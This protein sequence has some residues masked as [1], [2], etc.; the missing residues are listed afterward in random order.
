MEAL[1]VEVNMS[2]DEGAAKA[3][4]LNAPSV[5]LW[6]D[7][8]GTKAPQLGHREGIGELQ[9]VASPR[10]VK[11][12]PEEELQERWEAQWQEFL[13]TLQ[14][15][16]SGWGSLQKSV[17]PS[18]WEDTKA[19]LASFEQV[20][21]ACRW[22]R[23]KWVT[24]LLP[25]LSG[26]AEQAFSGLSSPDRGDYGK[27]KAA[28]LQGEAILR[29]RQR[30]HFRQFCYRDTEG[31]RAVYSR[32]RELC[33]QWLRA[34]RHTKEEILELLILEQFLTVLPQEMQSWVRERG[35]ETCAQAVV[36]AEDFLLKQ[37][38]VKQEGEFQLS[39]PLGTVPT[40]VVAVD[41]AE[42]SQA[43]PLG[44]WQRRV[45]QAAELARKGG[46][47]LRVDG[48]M[49][50]NKEGLHQ[51]S[52][53]QVPSKTESLETGNVFQY[54]EE[55]A[56]L[57]I[58]REPEEE[59]GKVVEKSV[60]ETL[61]YWEGGCQR[62]V[63]AAQKNILH[64]KGEKTHGDLGGRSRLGSDIWISHT[65]EKPQ[66][67]LCQVETSGESSTL[68]ANERS[69]LRE[70]PHKYSYCGRRFCHS[71]SVAAHER[72]Y[73]GV[74]ENKGYCLQQENPEQLEL[75]DVLLR[76]GKVSWHCGEGTRLGSQ[77]GTKPEK[78]MDGALP[79][80]GG[81]F[82][83]EEGKGQLK[84][85][86]CH[87]GRSFKYRC[88]LKAHE[89]IHTGERP[90]KCSDCGRS[91]GKGSTLRAHVRT[92]TGEKPYMCSMCGKRFTTRSGLL[93]HERIHTGEKPY[94]CSDCGRSFIQKS[95]LLAHEIS[96]KGE[97]SYT[98]S[99]CGKNFGHS[100]GLRV[101]RRIHL[102]G[103]TMEKL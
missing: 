98:C 28:I 65:A 78:T 31:P 88:N 32:L 42:A 63:T 2:V 99:D 21:S 40:M 9:A 94:K 26:E 90:H 103:R 18:P 45:C 36:L 57:R 30:Q 51:E 59:Q 79:S 41:S 54:Y 29:E 14:A 58:Q 70:K 66:E 12:E 61:S 6:A 62:K 73:T 87:C 91:F 1:S 82:G 71:E 10:Q 101:H 74:L 80:K 50:E 38:M 33:R 85:H 43:L 23:D 52:S 81:N 102:G 4:E 46:R 39:R 67:L 86:H 22:P 55:A 35:P 5:K 19:F 15:P 76:R 27:V 95:C 44:T 16:H 3:P 37:K 13:R 49:H 75:R 89:R 100:S 8:G 53:E 56:R 7:L 20:A 60:A 25:S 64:G 11:R 68:V 48:Q 93:T 34:E 83:W 77:Q 84:L 92:H 96:H 72:I 69:P 17:V 97:K 47:D 24:L